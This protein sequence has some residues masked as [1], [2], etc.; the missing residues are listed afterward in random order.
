MFY[1]LYI[2]QLQSIGLSVLEELKKNVRKDAFHT[3][4]LLRSLRLQVDM[5][6]IRIYMK[7]Y[8]VYLNSGIPPQNIPFG[9]GNGSRSKYIEGLERWAKSKGFDNPLSA[10]FAIA[11]K[12][13]S[14]GMP[15]RNF[16]GKSLQSLKL[17]K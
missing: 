10:A 1:A 4:Q 14:K 9:N 3:G 7:D 13:K 17:N 16:I 11:Q 8:G 5:E 15:A 2:K 12:H 6:Y